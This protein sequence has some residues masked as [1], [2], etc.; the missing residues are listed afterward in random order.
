MTGGE[1]GEAAGPQE[2]KLQ[3]AAETRFR[4]FSMMEPP[5]FDSAP[6]FNNIKPKKS[7]LRFL[8]HSLRCQFSA[9]SIFLSSNHCSLPEQIETY[10]AKQIFHSTYMATMAT[11]EGSS[12]DSAERL[13]IPSRNP[14]PLSAS[15][16]AQVRDIFYDRV[17]QQCAEEIKGMP[18]DKPHPRTQT[19]TPLC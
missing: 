4:R 2:P 18:P 13:P 8:K 14:L 11:G 16:E 5:S 17:R 7:T 12:S 15:Q 6:T 3:R 9:L 19:Q 10:S 1:G